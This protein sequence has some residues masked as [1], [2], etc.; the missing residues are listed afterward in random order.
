MMLLLLRPVTLNHKE[1]ALL[2]LPI[3][4]N[5]SLLYSMELVQRQY[6][7]GFL[8]PVDQRQC[9][10]QFWSCRP[11]PPGS[12]DTTSPCSTETVRVSL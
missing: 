9:S 6:C 7:G 8:T 12:Y 3:S 5:Q 10:H 1:V 11:S 4:P 2:N